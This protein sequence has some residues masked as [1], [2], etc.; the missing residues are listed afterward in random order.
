MKQAGLKLSPDKFIC[1]KLKLCFWVMLCLKTG[2]DLIQQMQQKW[3]N[4]QDL[5]MVSKQNNLFAKASYYRRFIKNF[6]NTARPL[7]E[8]TKKDAS[9]SW[10]EDCDNALNTL[11]S[12]LTSTDAVFFHRYSHTARAI[13]YTS[14]SLNKAE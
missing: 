8:L 2:N 12:A 9:F 11:K 7:I 4:S 10:T 5:Q 3:L 13:A 6:A 1:S 14:R